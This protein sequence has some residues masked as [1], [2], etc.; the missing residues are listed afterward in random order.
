MSFL[1]RCLNNLCN[2]SFKG[3]DIMNLNLGMKIK[4]L[5][6]SLNLTLE[7][8]GELIGNTAKSNVHA[9]ENGKSNP[10]KQKLKRIAEIAGKSVEEFISE[11]NPEA[12]IVEANYLNTALK[13]SLKKITQYKNILEALSKVPS[14]QLSLPCE[15]PGIN[16]S[17][18]NLEY[19]SLI[20]KDLSDAEQ[21][22]IQDASRLIDIQNQ[23]LENP[24][25]PNL[26]TLDSTPLEMFFNSSYPLSINEKS[27]TAE[28]KKRALEILKL[29]FK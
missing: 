19:I 20:E 29:V 15:A 8:F 23:L 10:N 26:N 2:N 5:R 1:Y 21:K 27:L 16:K 3:R 9:W 13:K 28:D 25:L 24:N 18:T 22:Y 7:E 17:I 4:I 6:E 12:S 14:D 11:E